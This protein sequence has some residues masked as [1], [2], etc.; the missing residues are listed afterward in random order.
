MIGIAILIYDLVV[1]ILVIVLMIN[2]E[3]SVG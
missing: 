1:I 2:I 3:R